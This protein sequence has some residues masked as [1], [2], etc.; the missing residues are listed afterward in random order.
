MSHMKQ[1][2]LISQQETSL[3]L[4]QNFKIKCFIPR[5]SHSLSTL[6][7]WQ[8]N[9][10]EGANEENTEDFFETVNEET[11]RN[12]NNRLANDEQ[13]TSS[14]TMASAQIVAG[15]CAKLGSKGE[16]VLYIPK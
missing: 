7:P 10:Y 11:D 9:F 16:Y 15:N 5:F 2:S 14:D 4:L 12:I 13:T 3:I 6:L 8:W 1:F